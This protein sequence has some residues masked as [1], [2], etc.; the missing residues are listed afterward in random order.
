LINL[1]QG[2]AFDSLNPVKAG[3]VTRPEDYEWSSYRAWAG[4][5]Q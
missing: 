2:Q 4:Y 5:D 3:I 1:D